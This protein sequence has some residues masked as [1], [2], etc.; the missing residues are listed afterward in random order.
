MQ[1]QAVVGCLCSKLDA[2]GEDEY[3]MI[4]DLNKTFLAENSG[5]KQSCDG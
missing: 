4:G 5:M 1:L 3:A 2:V